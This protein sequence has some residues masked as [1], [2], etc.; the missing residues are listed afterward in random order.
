MI[1]TWPYS[2]LYLC[3]PLVFTMCAPVHVR[4]V[5]ACTLCMFTAIDRTCWRQ[6]E[7]Q[8]T[9]TQWSEGKLFVSLFCQGQGCVYLHCPNTSWSSEMLFS[10][11]ICLRASLITTFHNNFVFAKI[12]IAIAYFCCRESCNKK[13]K[14]RHEKRGRKELVE[15]LLAEH[16]ATKDDPG[17]VELLPQ[18]WLIGVA[19]CIPNGS[20]DTYT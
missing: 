9:T 1:I 19:V 8:R 14:E 12:A 20:F 16:E 4:L 18:H 10:F 3:A 13:R 7:L 5:S 17:Y 2:T 11:H 15:A 6:T